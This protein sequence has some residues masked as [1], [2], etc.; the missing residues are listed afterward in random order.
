MT[1]PQHGDNVNRIVH[2]A[3]HEGNT[4]HG[5]VRVIEISFILIKLTSYYSLIARKIKLFRYIDEV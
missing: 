3:T 4:K 1:T 5:H 2:L